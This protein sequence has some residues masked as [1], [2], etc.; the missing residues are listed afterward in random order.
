M[1]WTVCNA[2]KIPG[3][4]P[5]FLKVFNQSSPPKK[6]MPSWIYKA[7]NQ[8]LGANYRVKAFQFQEQSHDETPW[9][10]R[11]RKGRE[12][13]TILKQVATARLEAWGLLNQI[14]YCPFWPVLCF[15][16]CANDFF[17]LSIFW[18]ATYSAKT[19]SP[20]HQIQRV[21]P[22]QWS[23]HPILWPV[24]WT[25]F[26]FGEEDANPRCQ[27]AQDSQGTRVGNR[28]VDSWVGLPPAHVRRGKLL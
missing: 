18:C 17:D 19:I 27:C 12:R 4:G 14:W 16:K 26:G 3:R 21:C 2:T 22:Y 28:W 7:W 13:I 23:H 20:W 1:W 5:W 24:S 15:E 9:S 25:S 6:I 11:G 10:F 8:A